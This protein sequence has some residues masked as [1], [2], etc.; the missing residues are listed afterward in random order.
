MDLDLRVACAYKT[1][2][3]DEVE[4]IG[5]TSPIKLVIEERGE[6]FEETSEVAARESSHEK[7]DPRHKTVAK[8]LSRKCELLFNPSIV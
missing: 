8:G 7:Y 2:S 3:V 1:I 6:R 5:K 4:V